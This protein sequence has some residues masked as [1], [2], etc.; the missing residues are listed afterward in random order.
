MQAPSVNTTVGPCAASVIA[1]VC[2]VRGT[3]PRSAKL[4]IVI[5]DGFSHQVPDI[6]PG[7]TGEWIDSFDEVLAAQGRSRARFLLMKLLERARESQVGFPATVSTPYVNTIPA[8][9][10]PWFPGDE[11][12]ERRIRAYLRWNAAVMVT[13]A[14]ARYSGIGGHLS[15]Y[16]SS[17]SLYEVGFN[18][19]FHGKEHGAA[20]DQVYFQ[21]HA[22]PGIYARAFVEGR[23]EAEHL[24]NFRFE[25]A[26]DG[27]SSY[28][29]PRL[30]PSFWE[31]PTVSMGLGPL[32]AVYQAR[33]NRYLQH[34]RIL[35]T[36]ASRVWC[37]VGDGEFDEPETR[38]GLS[39]AA[40]E[41]L[42][43][44]VFVV[45]C[46]L[47]RLDGPVRGNGKVIQ[48]LEAEFRGS[49]WNV[50]KVIWGSRW[51]ELL[52]RDVDGVLVNKMNTTVDGEFQK[53]ATESGAYVREHFFGPDP[54]L[55]ALV[56]HL[57]DEE[58]QQ[59]PRGGHDYRKL[60]AAYQAAAEQEGAPTAILAK[61]VKGWM[62]GPE[63]ESR[64]ATHQIKK[65]TKEQLR[66]LRDRLHVTEEIP[67]EVL[68]G[69]GAPY[70]R[71]PKGSPAY[72]YLMTRK[73][74]LG[75]S[76]P[77]RV[78]RG[79]GAVGLPTPAPETFA[80]FWQGSRGQA[81]STTMVFARLLRNL[82]REPQIGRFV[83]PIIPDEGRTFGLDALFSEVKIYASGGQQ[84]TSVDA[85]LLLQYAEADDGQILEEG[86][87]EAGAMASF[88]AAATSYSTWSRPMLPIFLYYSMFG[89]QRIG[90]MIWQ[91]A[92]ARGRGFLIG[93]TAGR[94]TMNGEGLQHEDGHSLLLASA[95]PSVRA[96]DPAFAYEVATIV[97]RGIEEM[98]GPQSNDV[99]YYL[100]LYNENYVMPALPEGDEAARIREGT[101]AGLYRFR[102]PPE[103]A[104]NGGGTP[105][106]ATI[107]FSGTAWQAAER[108]R[109]MLATDWNVAAET[110]SVTSYKELREDALEVERWN[111]LHPS[112]APRVPYVARSL[113]DASGPI[114]AVTDFMKAVPDQ[115]SR[116]VHGHFTSLGTDGF[117]MSDSREALRRHF[118][119]DAEHVVVAVLSAL[120]STGQAKE[121]EVARALALFG[122]D[123]EAPDPRLT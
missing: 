69:P 77:H 40:R 118:E 81:V 106:P 37:F 108:A 56:E 23:L 74:V 21:G 61:T 41:R 65:M 97:E 101:L 52:A 64:N 58:L 57:S 71:P 66:H 86:I 112:G 59:L 8:D 121:E 110:W 43:N 67:D 26:G 120:V 25:V 1:P 123:T 38:A 99:M 68:E 72:E 5:F 102:G 32:S 107:L 51:D 35:D 70:Y 3:G 79:Q 46:N 111:R 20:G 85:G 89:F 62:L 73:Q 63:I 31:Y 91:C 98:Y 94:T 60:Y 47:Q 50:I 78:V 82:L 30:M 19:F 84:Y 33:F 49:G 87:T 114:V 83:V 122:I 34:R 90:D 42:D 15:T 13:R 11:E 36:S 117:G 22:S 24:D 48:E 10:E 39:L 6:D 16:A 45:N 75:G 115:I 104:P 88:I 80:E 105:R 14:N 103:V 95:Y 119:V 7:E 109:E 55:R 76:L 18:H 93:A 100:T 9:Q 53:L 12:M 2:P 116:F 92:D 28:P 17:A 4:A 29:H 54:R 113:A 96:Y 27:L 44:L